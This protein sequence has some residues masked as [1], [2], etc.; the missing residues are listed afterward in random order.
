MF[1]SMSSSIV[2]SFRCVSMSV[3]ALKS[4]VVLLRVR[5]Y[6]TGID[7]TTSGAV[8]SVSALGLASVGLRRFSVGR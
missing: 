7:A 8:F 3:C 6:A 4:V 2:C 1:A 5:A